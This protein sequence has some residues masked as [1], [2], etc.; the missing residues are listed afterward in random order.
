MREV[1]SFKV[2]A[3]EKIARGGL[4]LDARA[5]CIFHFEPA[6][7]KAA[8]DSASSSRTAPTVKREIGMP[9]VVLVR[10]EMNRMN[11]SSSPLKLDLNT[12]ISP[13]F[14]LNDRGQFGFA[15]KQRRLVPPL[16]MLLHV[17]AYHLAR[18]FISLLW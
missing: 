10:G 1:R 14:G 11:G 8:S 5:G 12:N 6:S 9:N 15:Q 16:V 13:A 3:R 7:L 2:T 18:P 4:E 17:L